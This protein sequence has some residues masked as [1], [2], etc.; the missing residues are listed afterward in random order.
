MVSQWLEKAR[1]G[2]AVWLPDVREQ[3]SGASDCVDVTMQLTLCDGTQ[4]DLELPLPRWKNAEERR[5]VLQYA[6]A[7]VYNALSA[8]SGRKLTFY[9]PPQE[10]EAVALLQEL[11]DV[12]QLHA[13]QRS[14]YG[15][16]INIADRLCRAFGGGRFAFSIRSREDYF[17]APPAASPAGALTARLRQAAA[18]CGHGVCCG[19]DI[20]G[21]D[22]KAAA[23]VD[24]RLVCVKEYDWDPS[25]SPT[26]EGIIAPI[27]LLTRLLAC[28]A[29][30]ITPVLE[31][32]LAKNAPDAFMA[33]AV[34][35]SRALPIDVLGIS[36]PDVVI[37]DRIV[38]GETPKTKG[39]RENRAIDYE[40]AFAQLGRLPEQL[41]P[42]CR[43]DAAIHMTNDGHIAAFTAAAELAR[44][45]TPDFSGGIV[46]HAL[47]TDFGMGF[48]A[49]DGTIPEMPMEL[50]DFLL[51][52]GS[53]PQRRLSPDDLRSTRNENSGLPG[54][55]RYLG[56]AAAFRLAYEAAPS[57]LDGF[58][59]KQNDVLTIPPEKR[60]ACLAFLMERAAQND[61]AAQSVFRSVGRHIGQISREMAPLLRPQ[62]DIRYLFGRFVKEPVC[63]RLL[64][65]GCREIAP[66]LRLEAADEELSCTP[67]MR[68]LSGHGATVAQFGQAIGAMYFAAMP[69]VPASMR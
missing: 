65:E 8:C 6:T 19:I 36:F 69:S 15:K 42:L 40:T 14:G 22:I 58:V 47:G 41:R 4:R 64:Q 34:A 53:F 24:G 67:L 12:F 52:L 29:A 63:F 57:L 66:A 54:A 11:E 62:T 43:E 60:K 35:E 2:Q 39:M 16:V 61:G 38:G 51:D 68:A 3:C 18:R 33:Q 23:A 45:S 44:E 9:L 28:C 20:G 48:L 26:A 56:Q 50:Y 31:Q 13:P 59:Q 7:C 37:R 30:G 49:P 17:P 25:S 27:L 1:S 21:T 32:A 10:A 55:R 5:F 46:A